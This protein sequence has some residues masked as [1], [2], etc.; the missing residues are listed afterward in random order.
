M[1]RCSYIGSALTAAARSAAVRGVS[2]SASATTEVRNNMQ[3]AWQRIGTCQIQ[4]GL[5]RTY[6]TLGE[7]LLDLHLTSF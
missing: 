4:Q 5:D 1:N 2:P 3:A 7:C 6:V